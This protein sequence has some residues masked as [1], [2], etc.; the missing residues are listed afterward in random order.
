MKTQYHCTD[1]NSWKPAEAF[2]ALKK[3]KK[4][5]TRQ[6]TY[7]CRDCCAVRN[8]KAYQKNK[9][10][11][12]FRARCRANSARYHAEKSAQNRLDLAVRRALKQEKAALKKECREVQQQV[13]AE[14]DEQISTR[15]QVRVRAGALGLDKDEVEYAFIR[16]SGLCDICGS[17]PDRTRTRLC[18]EHSHHT[19]RFRGFT[20]NGCNGIMAFADDDPDRLRLVIGYLATHQ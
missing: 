8:R 6:V 3:P 12:E 11:A 14:M 7:W 20:C 15:R 10:D 13:R 18:I 16:H 4:G 19:G 5:L 2:Y 1:C 17:G 9:Q